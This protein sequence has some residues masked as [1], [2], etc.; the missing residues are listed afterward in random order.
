MSTFR[1]NA[2]DEAFRGGT[3]DGF[4]SSDTIV[5]FN[6]MYKGDSSDGFAHA[7]LIIEF[8]DFSKGGLSD[9]Y[10]SA[11][12]ENQLSQFSYGGIS[13]GFAGKH[14]MSDL[15]NFTKGGL[16]DGHAFNTSQ[17]SISIFSK[18]GE[19]DGFAYE[20]FGHTI[21]WTGA[22]GTGWNVEG[23]WANNIIPQYYN[24][25]IIPPDVPNFPKVNA[26]ILRIGHFENDGDYTCEKIKIESGAELT[27]RLNCF[28]ENYS[29]I[30]NFGT[31]YVRNQAFNA[32]QNLEGG[33]LK[34]K[35]N[36]FMFFE[37]DQ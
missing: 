9:G 1:I 12:S 22:I 27:A 19:D 34:L 32:F 20:I 36:S 17:N 7:E 8:V 5:T 30:N 23:N 4:T 3:G 21:Y 28:V 29:T 13:D 35:P 33:V 25:V 6:N 2:Q 31:I 16:A 11:I 15:I 24:P 18:G 14:L 37:P 26:G 10:T